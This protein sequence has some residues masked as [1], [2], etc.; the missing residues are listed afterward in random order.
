MT[1]T[2]PSTGPAVLAVI[3]LLAWAHSAPAQT[4]PVWTQK[5]PADVEAF[6]FAPTGAVVVQTKAG[7]FA[8]EPESG[9]RLWSRPDVRSYALVAGTPFAIFTTAAGQSVAGIESGQDRWSLSSLG[10][11]SIKGQVHLPAAGLMLVYGVTPKSAHTL[12]ACKY[13]SGETVWTQTSLFSAPAVAAKA[14]K[15]EYHTWVLDTETTVVLDPSH[16]GLL[17][18]DLKTGELLWRIPESAL[19][20]KGSALEM[21][22]TGRVALGFYDWGKKVLGIDLDS[23]TVLWTRKEKFPRPVLQTAPTPSGLL[24]R[25]AFELTSQGSKVSWHPYL[26]LIDPMTGATKWMVEKEA[27]G[28]RSS[29]LLEGDTLTVAAEDAVASYDAASG[30]ALNSVKMTAFSGGESPQWLERSEDGG[31]IVSSPQNLRKFEASG[32]L[33][34]STYLKAPGAGFLAKF[35]MF[36]LGAALAGLTGYPGYGY[37]T[38]D[39]AVD[40]ARARFKATTSARRYMYVFTEEPGSESARFALVRLDKDTGKDTGRLRFNE[41]APSFRLDWPTGFV[42]VE[43]EGVLAGYRFP[44]QPDR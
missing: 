17:R 34:H 18:L 11:S 3:A 10:F 28:G 2:S 4:P 9:T 42:V 33:V 26:A 20:S 14:S 7:L 21:I 40:Y 27:Y 16:D 15:V 12:V 5:L 39:V 43:H 23:G 36:A 8:V 1:R 41:R 13:L 35:G 19:D 32:A 25:G 30:A 6:A 38:L 37:S 31:L 24:V 29:F 44:P 22:S